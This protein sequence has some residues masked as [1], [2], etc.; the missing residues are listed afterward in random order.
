[1]TQISLYI[2][3]A[4]ASKLDAAARRSKCSVSK[5]VETIVSE[6]LSKEPTA[7]YTAKNKAK[8][9]SCAFGSLAKYAN[10]ALRKK[11]KDIWEIHSREKYATR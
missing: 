4:V 6:R 11:E 9:E 2:E 8:T 3:D 1:M 10:P 7:N 5:Y